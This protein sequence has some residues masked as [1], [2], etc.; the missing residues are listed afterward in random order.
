MSDAPIKIFCGNSNIELAR[1]IVEYLEM[2]LGCAVIKRFADGEVAISISESVRG[3]HVYIVQSICP[4]ANEHLMELLV[5]IDALKRASAAA[6]TV[7]L[8]YYGYAR[9]DR[10]AAP[11]EPITAKLV[12]DLLE[13]AGANRLIS[14]D[15][16]AAQI[17]GFFNVPFDHLYAS[18]IFIQ[19]IKERYVQSGLD[20]ENLVVVSPD[21][22]GVER[23]RAY[24]KRLQASLAIIDK[25]RPKPGIAEVM[26]II[27]DVKGKRAVIIDD[28]IDTAGTLVKAAE[29][30]RAQ[31][32]K[33]ISSYASHGV[34]SPPAVERISSSVIDEVVITNTIPLREDAVKCPKIRVLSCA[35]LVGEAISRVHTGASVSS[36]FI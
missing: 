28:M 32:A 2:P 22:G 12:A 9:Q 3:Y 10:K 25:R 26:N 7:V 13:A 30:I 34:F 36:L 20:N 21:A 24:A 31:G 16:H 19:D 17:Q 5:M 8:P 1:R 14:L 33:H 35:S 27:G 4:P 15:L 23:A 29:A 18:P 11:R 6:I